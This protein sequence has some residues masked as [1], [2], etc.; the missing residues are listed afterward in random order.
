MGDVTSSSTYIRIGH[1]VTGAN[2]SYLVF[3]HGSSQIGSVSQNSSGNQTLYNQT[4]DYRLKENIINL[5]GAI[6]RIKQLSPRRFNFIG[7][8][9]N[10]V[11]GFIAHEVATVVPQA[12]S[13]THNEVDSDNNPVYQQIDQSKLI[14]VLTAAL[15]EEIAKREALEARIAALEGS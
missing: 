5:D 9:D 11:D 10:T 3:G 15:K 6:T 14:P 4:S 12:V 2:Y 7:D 8:S 13:G 1:N